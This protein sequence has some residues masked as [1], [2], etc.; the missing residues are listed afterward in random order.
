MG[1]LKMGT[2]VQGS[3]PRTRVWPCCPWFRMGVATC[4]RAICLPLDDPSI[5]WPE[6]FGRSGGS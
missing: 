2:P 4:R 1:G 5:S 3:G 6:E